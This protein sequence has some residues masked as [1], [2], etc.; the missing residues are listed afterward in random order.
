MKNLLR[1]VLYAGILAV[2]VISCRREEL[3]VPVTGVA[4]SPETLEIKPGEQAIVTAIVSPEDAVNKDVVFSSS[5]ETVATVTQDGVVEGLSA[6]T[7]IIAITTVDGNFKA[8]CSVTVLENIAAG[9]VIAGNISCRNAVISGTVTIP[10]KEIQGL[11]FGIQYSTYPDFREYLVVCPEAE[12]CDAANNFTVVT[13][14]LEPETVYYC[15]SFVANGE[16]TALGEI[17]S[18]KTLPLS[19]M[20]QTLDP[21]GLS[22]KG[23]E[24]NAVLVLKDCIYKDLEYG[25][26]LSKDGTLAFAAASDNLADGKF[27]KTA[28]LEAES[29]YSYLAYVKL[30]GLTYKAESKGFTS[31]ATPVSGVEISPKSAEIKIGGSVLVTATVSPQNAGNRSVVFSSSDESVATV[32]QEGAIRGVSAGTAVVTATTVDGNFT[33]E[34]TVKVLDM[35]VSSTGTVSNISCRNAIISGAAVRPDTE[36]YEFS[37]GIMYSTAADFKDGATVHLAAEFVDEN[38]NFS[39]VTGVLEPE[40]TYYYRSYM[41]DGGETVLGEVKSFRTLAVSSMI[42]SLD[43]DIEGPKKV[44]F[45][46][47]YNLKDC[48]YDKA[49]F[50]FEFTLDGGIYTAEADR[51]ADGQMK[52]GF[53]TKP[54]TQY[55]YTAYVILDGRRYM[56]E[57]KT[58]TTPAIQA[59]VTLDDMDSDCQS[60]NYAYISG[61]VKVESK[62]SYVLSGTLYYSKTAS[63]LSTLKAGGTPV[64]LDRTDFFGVTL[65]NLPSDTKYYYAVV[66]K[67]DDAEFNSAVKTFSTTKISGSVTA[68]ASDITFDLARVS[69]KVECPTANNT[70]ARSAVLYYSSTAS[71]VSALKSNGT[72]KTL[73]LDSEGKY[74]TELTLG[75][76]M[77]YYYT[78]VMKAYDAEFDSGVNSF[79]KTIW[80]DLGLSVKWSR[81]DLGAYSDGEAGYVFQWA[82]TTDVTGKESTLGWA[83]A[84]YHNGDDP[85]SGWTKYNIKSTS[86]ELESKDDAATKSL[87]NGWRTPTSG[88]WQELYKNCSRISATV[89]GVSGYKFQSNIS[90]YTDKWIFI[91]ADTYWSSSFDKAHPKFAHAIYPFKAQY[92]TCERYKAFPVRPVYTK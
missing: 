81:L 27:S 34:C 57:T 3:S 87:G 75:R 5:K 28:E 74:S 89:N 50:G 35:M 29:E 4:A 20:I 91:P 66:A 85:N 78:V 30:D 90:G 33:A 48:V 46:G 92:G 37:F 47:S 9:K 64:T 73:T 14:V 12:S 16:E 77:K 62:G 42:Q 63:T 52:E 71:T 38:N 32:S 61:R 54:E 76:D 41:S 39:V 22:S 10:E 60:Y 82:G 88:E 23:C 69:G 18:F 51:F 45:N 44:T 80:V 15:R 1:T 8:F 26:E 24:M 55:S 6:G 67:V 58:F 83:N 53:S 72:A 86:A 7:A 68:G 79:E 25:F 13:G 21:T 49:E 40:T 36:A 59:T 84:P 2:S 17:S 56:G 11:S 31:P 43:P 65:E 70:I 19:S